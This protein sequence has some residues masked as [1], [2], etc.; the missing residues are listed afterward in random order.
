MSQ[1][2]IAREQHD[3]ANGAI[4]FA[5]GGSFD[6]LGPFA[7]VL[8]CPVKV[9]G[10]EIDLIDG[11]FVDTRVYLAKRYTC[12]ASGIADTF[13]SVPANTKIRGKSVSG[14]FSLDANDGCE[15]IPYSRHEARLLA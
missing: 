8:N 12:Y 9:R 14:F 2:Y 6:C 4:G 7:K 10:S 11:E 1:R 13:F 15:F 3:F 5:P